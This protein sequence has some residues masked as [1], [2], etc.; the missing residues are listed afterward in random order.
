MIS[1]DVELSTVYVY[2]T[3]KLRDYRGRSVFELILMTKS[4][5]VLQVSEVESAVKI[6]WSGK[7]DFTSNIMEISTS[8]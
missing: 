6:L 4:Y 8:Y 1:S 7:V 2:E 3:L 5:E